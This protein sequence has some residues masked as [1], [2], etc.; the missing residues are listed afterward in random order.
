MSNWQVEP[1]IFR[2]QLGDWVLF[3]ASLN[4]QTCRYRIFDQGDPVDSPPLP[5]IAPAKDSDGYAIR[6]VHIKKELPVL[7]CAEHY[8]RYVPLQYLHCYMDLN[9]PYERYIGKFSAKTRATIQ[10]KIRKFGDHCGGHISWKAYT[11]SEELDEFFSLARTVS[12]LTYQE[13]LLNVGLPDS[14]DFRQMANLLA[15]ENRLRAFVL[16]DASRHP[17][18]YLYCP[19]RDG[20]LVYAYLGYDPGYHKLSVGTVLQWLA[21]EYI[22]KENKFLYFDFTEGK[23]AHKEL[24]ATHQR[25]CANVYFIKRTPQ[26]WL[27]V[28]T[29]VLMDQLSH[30]FGSALARYG[31][32]AKVKQLLR[33]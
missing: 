24:F 3:S 16:F 32:K 27:L 6:N 15:V 11:R 28:K 26:N 1:V 7:S 10:R 8:I 13:R 14:E 5:T 18:A 12:K 31:L 20:V 4:M 30:W 25:L 23:S 29:H 17:I 21:T 19:E 2:Y 33:S 9:W 22:Y